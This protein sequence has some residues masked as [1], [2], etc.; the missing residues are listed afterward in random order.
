MSDLKTFHLV[1]GVLLLAL[2]WCV[3]TWLSYAPQERWVHLLAVAQQEQLRGIP[4]QAL[5]EQ[6]PWLLQ[7]RL[8]R[9]SQLRL[10]LGLAA[11]IGLAEGWGW[12]RSDTLAGFRFTLWVIGTVGGAIV[13]GGMV[14]SL[15]MPWALPLTRTVCYGLTGIVVVITFALAAGLPHLS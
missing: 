15:L 1:L 12:R 6:A 8:A 4:P 11:V 2:L 3:L 7:A 10:L 13:L 9:L 14:F 5:L